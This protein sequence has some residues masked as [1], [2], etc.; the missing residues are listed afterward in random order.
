MI[1]V[2]VNQKS[3]TQPQLVAFVLVLGEM[4]SGLQKLGQ[5]FGNV[6]IPRSTVICNKFDSN[7]T[8]PIEV[9]VVKG[10]TEGGSGGGVD[11][12]LGLH[13]PT[14]LPKSRSILKAKKREHRTFPFLL[15]QRH[16]QQR[17]RLRVGDRTTARSVGRIEWAKIMRFKYR[18]TMSGCVFDVKYI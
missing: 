5:Y 7:H 16:Q 11:G 1:C 6:Q 8:L 15:W 10:Y 12:C 2:R 14:R 13:S 18:R 9:D 3:T 17:R 4:C